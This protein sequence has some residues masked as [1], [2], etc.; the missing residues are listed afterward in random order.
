MVVQKL[1]GQSAG[2]GFETA[3]AVFLSNTFPLLANLRPG[4][5]TVKNFGSSRGVYQM[6][7]V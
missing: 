6:A 4:E 1:S 7:T 5:W 2:K 3:V